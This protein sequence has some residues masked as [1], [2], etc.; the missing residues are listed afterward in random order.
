MDE[1]IHL[2]DILTQVSALET[3]IARGRMGG[4]PDGIDAP[5][6]DL[7]SALDTFRAGATLDRTVT[8]DTVIG[9]VLSESER[10]RGAIRTAMCSGTVTVRDSEGLDAMVRAISALR[11]EVSV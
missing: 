9:A 5:L 1:A 4:L 2:R 6:T 10:L 3:A 11:R 7:L 8:R